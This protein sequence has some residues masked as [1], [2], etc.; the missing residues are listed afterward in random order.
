MGEVSTVGLDIQVPSYIN[1]NNRYFKNYICNT[2]TQSYK[3]KNNI[4][5]RLKSW[6]FKKYT[7][8]TRSHMDNKCTMKQCACAT[9]H[10]WMNDLCISA[11][12]SWTSKPVAVHTYTFVY[13]YTQQNSMIVITLQTALASFNHVNDFSHSPTMETNEQLLHSFSETADCTGWLNQCFPNIFPMRSCWNN[14]PN[15]QEPLYM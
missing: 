9:E 3:F 11:N 5:L 12:A 6:Y 14:Y 4:Y 13:H 10:K 15:P 7:G 2:H 1:W 8:H